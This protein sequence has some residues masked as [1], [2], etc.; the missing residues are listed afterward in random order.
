MRGF[1]YRS[2]STSQ[3]CMPIPR[4]QTGTSAPLYSL[5]G[6]WTLAEEVLAAPDP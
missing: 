5:K 1:D 2:F 3:I 6:E 4:R